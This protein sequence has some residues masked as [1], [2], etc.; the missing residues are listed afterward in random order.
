MNF[1]FSRSIDGGNVMKKLM[2]IL[3]LV[4]FLVGCGRVMRSEFYQHDTMYR[5]WDHMA[6]SWFGYRNTTAEDLQRSDQQDWWGLEIPYVPG[7]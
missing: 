5:N 1:Y 4:F 2:L 6:F 3:I 7:E